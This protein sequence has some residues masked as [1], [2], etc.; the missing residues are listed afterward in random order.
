MLRL[1]R[2][3]DLRP[4]SAMGAVSA[5]RLVRGKKVRFELLVYLHHLLAGEA[6]AGGEF[7]DRFEVVILST[8]QAPVE[9]APLSCRR[10]S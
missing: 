8:R 2:D 9:H 10:R 7:G 6:A 4:S 3:G 1:I 5:A